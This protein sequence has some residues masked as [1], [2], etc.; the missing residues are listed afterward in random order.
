MRRVFVILLCTLG[1]S[2]ATAEVMPKD[3]GK[4]M[5]VLTAK[6]ARAAKKAEE[7]KELAEC[8]DHWDPGTHM[9]KK[10]WMRT[11]RRVQER[12]RQLDVR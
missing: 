12:F 11:C 3:A 10:V 6:E 4:R 2:A 1:V 7:E 8:M 5:G 9:T